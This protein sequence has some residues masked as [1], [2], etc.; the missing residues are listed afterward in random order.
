VTGKAWYGR[1]GVTEEVLK[2]VSNDLSNLVDN[3]K[4]INEV[5]RELQTLTG[6]DKEQKERELEMKKKFLIQKQ[7]K[8]LLDPEKS[9]Q[10]GVTRLLALEGKQKTFGSKFR[11]TSREKNTT[12]MLRRLLYEPDIISRSREIDEEV[13]KDIK[14]SRRRT[15]GKVDHLQRRIRPVTPPD[16]RSDGR[17]RP[18]PRSPGR[19]RPGPRSPGRARPRSPGRP[20]KPQ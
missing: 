4:N 20:R 8:L 3:Q 5:E 7:A 19:A 1:Y 17:A 15:S 18:G 14:A 6:T 11:N 9:K 2:G 16:N 13:K 10:I 12:K